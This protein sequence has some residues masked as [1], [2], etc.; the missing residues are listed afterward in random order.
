[1]DLI[2]KRVGVIGTGATAVQLIPEIANEVAHLTIFHRTANY[3][4]PL[5]NGPI[6]PEWQR[7]IKASYPEIFKKC[8]ETPGG[9]VHEFDPRSALDVSEEARLAQYE[10]LWAEPRFKKWLANYQDIMMPGE[11]NEDYAEFVRNKIRERVKDPVVAVMLVPK[12]HPFGSK[13]LPCET[14]YYDVYNRD[15][16]LLV[17]VR[18]APIECITPWA[19]RPVLPNMNWTSSSLP[20]DMTQG[21]GR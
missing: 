10:R 2:G 20:R 18:E 17:N 13:L 3:C 16:V 4:A 19:S 5:R 14:G 21:P 12:D 6:D 1:M 7:E 15:N 9:F 11:A 8:S